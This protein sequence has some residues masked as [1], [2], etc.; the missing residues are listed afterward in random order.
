M[1][2]FN[3]VVVYITAFLLASLVS[4]KAYDITNSLVLE[5]F[6]DK[7]DSNS[8]SNSDSKSDSNNI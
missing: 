7:S 2:S 4:S 6:L 8:N 5:A 3:N 1:V